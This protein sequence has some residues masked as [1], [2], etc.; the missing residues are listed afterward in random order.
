MPK[1]KTYQLCL[2]KK[3][4]KLIRSWLSFPSAK[5]KSEEKANPKRRQGESRFSTEV[6]S[7]EQDV[8]LLRIYL[9]SQPNPT[10]QNFQELE[11]FN[12]GDELRAKSMR[13]Y[14]KMQDK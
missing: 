8:S 6:T 2:T 10:T 3:K 4:K 1:C 13:R 7:E 12:D 9:T 5:T 14:S 11:I